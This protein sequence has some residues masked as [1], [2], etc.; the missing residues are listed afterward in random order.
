MSRP[1]EPLALNLS[2]SAALL[3]V[4]PDF[5]SE[6]VLSELRIVRRGRLRLVPRAELQRWLDENAEAVAS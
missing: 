6:H 3:G 5:F 1:T 4:S 2:D